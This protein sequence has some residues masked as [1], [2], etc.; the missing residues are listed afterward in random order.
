MPSKVQTSKVNTVVL[1]YSHKSDL[2]DLKKYKNTKT[3][4][5]E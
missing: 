3:N 2:W 5:L 4:V 1:H